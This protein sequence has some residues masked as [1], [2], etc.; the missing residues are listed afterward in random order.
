[1]KKDAYMVENPLPPMREQYRI[2]LNNGATEI[3]I[4]HEQTGFKLYR[5][6]ICNKSP[7][8]EMDT[9]LTEEEMMNVCL[10]MSAVKRHI[11]A[12]RERRRW[13]KNERQ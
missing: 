1:M 12:E 3:Y 5:I 7:R 8:Y 9:T 13:M 11:K 4:V 10:M 2:L 6:R